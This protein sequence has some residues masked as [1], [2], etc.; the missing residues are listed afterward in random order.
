MKIDTKNMPNWSPNR[1]QN[2]S[3][4]NAKNGIEK[5]QENH[6]I[7]SSSR[8]VSS[9]QIIVKTCVSEGLAGCVRER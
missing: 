6:E 7:S 1:C 2:A 8:K 4:I 5:D 9:L 3:E